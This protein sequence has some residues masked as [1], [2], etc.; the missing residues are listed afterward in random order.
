MRGAQ[1]VDGLL[2]AIPEVPIHPDDVAGGSAGVVEVHDMRCLAVVRVGAAEFHQRGFLDVDLFRDGGF[3]TAE[4]VHKP[5][6]HITRRDECLELILSGYRCLCPEIPGTLVRHRS[7][8]VH[9]LDHVAHA[10]RIGS[11]GEVGDDRDV[12]DIDIVDFRILTTAIAFGDHRHLVFPCGGITHDGVAVRGCAD[13]CPFEGPVE[14]DVLIAYGRGV[15][16][17]LDIHR[18]FADG[19][20]DDPEVRFDAFLDVHDEGDFIFESVCRAAALYDPK[21]DGVG[22]AVIFIDVLRVRD[23]TGGIPVT[24]VPGPG[25]DRTCCRVCL[26]LKV[27]GMREAA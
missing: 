2:D 4:V 5:D 19:R 24:E 9:E 20:G 18:W 10:H 27:H 16:L 14:C 13:G 25:T 12:G 26:V 1:R 8:V 3:A 15:V 11:Y 7:G 6:G 17:E 22:T 23:I 21:R